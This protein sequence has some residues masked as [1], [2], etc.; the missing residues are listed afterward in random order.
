M[1]IVEK[2][3]QSYTHNGHI[4]VL[5]E[6]GLE[7]SMPLHS[8]EFIDF[9]VDIAMHIAAS[10]PVNINE[11]LSQPFIKNTEISIRELIHQVVLNISEEISVTRYVCLDTEIIPPGSNGL[12]PKSPA[13]AMRLV[14]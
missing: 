14:K 9:T 13:V 8:D 1:K 7:S 3:I 2:F 6:F 10:K 5:V 4:G 11:L 12:P